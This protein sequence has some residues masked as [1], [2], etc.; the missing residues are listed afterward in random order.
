MYLIGFFAS[1]LP[2]IALLALYMSGYAFFTLTTTDHDQQAAMAEAV[3][4]KNTEAIRL[5]VHKTTT[6]GTSYAFRTDQTPASLF[7]SSDGPSAHHPSQP[8]GTWLTPPDARPT[9]IYP[10]QTNSFAS[11]FLTTHPIRPPPG[12]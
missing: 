3:S 5:P 6:S 11:L 7:Y 8:P 10:S 1:P 4:A 2:Y 12:A 9:I